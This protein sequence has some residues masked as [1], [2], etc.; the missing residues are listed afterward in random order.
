M[1]DDVH[2]MDLASRCEAN[3]ATFRTVAALYIDGLSYFC[4]AEMSQPDRWCPL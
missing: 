1:E 2:T 3:P 4:D